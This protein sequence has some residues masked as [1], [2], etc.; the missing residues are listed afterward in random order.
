MTSIQTFLEGPILFL[1]GVDANVQFAAFLGE[2]VEQKGQ[3]PRCIAVTT[4]F[5]KLLEY[6]RRG[7]ICIPDQ[8][9]CDRLREAAELYGV[10]PARLRFRLPGRAT[11][12]PARRG[13]LSRAK[14][15]S[16]AR[17]QAPPF[18]RIKRI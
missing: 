12:P 6:F 11:D 17:L 10:D 16:L 18:K 5:A 13:N 9:T 1:E 14:C 3:F 15:G 8:Q 2:G 7:R 4:G